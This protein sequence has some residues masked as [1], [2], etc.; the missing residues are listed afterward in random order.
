MTRALYASA[1]GYAY[2]EGTKALRGI[3]LEIRQGEFVALLASNGS[4]KTT[5]IKLLA[6]LLEMQEGVVEIGGGDIRTVPPQEL[7]RRIGVTF[8]N[9]DDQLFAATVEDD[10]AFGPRNMGFDE[11]ETLRRVRNALEAVAALE[12][13]GKA[14]HHLSFGQKKRVALA[15]VLAMEPQIL[16][17][18]E[19]TA[20]LDPAGEGNVMRLLGKIN[21]ERNVTMVMATHSVDMLPLFADR[22]VVLKDGLLLKQGA[23]EE[24]FADHG[25]LEQ[26]GLRL[27]YVSSLIHKMKEHDGLPM[28]GLP[29]T[30]GEARKRFLELIPEDILLKPARRDG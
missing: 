7:Y 22:I 13:G 14:I 29:L 21:R 18:D 3:D 17:L 5:L 12:L 19:P 6:G 23:P 24:V 15:G 10:V 4:G 11:I 27:P 26:A 1:L 16:L 9:P 25:L 8:Q 20:G 28:N 30:I 2:A